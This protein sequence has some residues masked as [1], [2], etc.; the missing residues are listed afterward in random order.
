MTTS[1]LA[2]STPI[3]SQ[4]DVTSRSFASMKAQLIAY[5]KRNFP[6][7]TSFVESDLG[8]SLIEQ[9]CYAYAVIAFYQDQLGNEVY[10]DTIRDPRNMQLALRL[11]GYEMGLPTPASVNVVI[12]PDTI[13]NASEVVIP[14]GT[15][16]FSSG[17]LPFETL[18]EYTIIAL[19]AAPHS[20]WTVNGKQ[21]SVQPVIPVVQ[22][23][24]QSFST[25]GNGEPFQEITLIAT[26]VIDKS[27]SITIGGVPWSEVES[28]VIGDLEDNT[29]LNVFQVVIDSGGNGRLLFGDGVNGAIPANGSAIVGTY[30]TGGGSVGNVAI[31]AINTSVEVTV[32]GAPGSITVYNE[33]TA[34]GGND[35]E[36]IEHARYFGPLTV[37]TT[38]RAITYGDYF[39]L[40]N[41]FHS[42]SAGTVAKAGIVADPTDGISNVVTV[43]IWAADENGDIVAGTSQALKDAL[44]TFLIDRKVVT[45]S[46][47]VVDG[48][49]VPVDLKARIVT[50]PGYDP[51]EV[52][53]AVA[54]RLESLFSDSRV[55]Y[56]NELRGSWVYDI[57]QSTPGVRWCVI[58]SVEGSTNPS[59]FDPLGVMQ[60]KNHTAQHLGEDDI[61][62]TLTPTNQ[63]PPSATW[64]RFN[65]N[66]PWE[67][68][69]SGPIEYL[70]SFLVADVSV[71]GSIGASQPNHTAPPPGTA[72]NPW[73]PILDHFSDSTDTPNLSPGDYANI[74]VVPLDK[75]TSA[76]AAGL[77]AP[78]SSGQGGWTARIA[79]PRL[80]RLQG[81]DL[82]FKDQY[83]FHSI[84]LTDGT[85]KGQ[86]RTIVR[87]WSNGFGYT[88]LF[89]EVVQVDKDWD[90]IPDDTT[91]YVILP[92][93][94]V[95]PDMTMVRGNIEVE[96]LDDPLAS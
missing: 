9:I 20:E 5:W 39:A 37:K 78:V 77:Y 85:G 75:I 74:G 42:S 50:S 56:D 25:T 11:I 2:L 96:I 59:P 79:H 23:E 93:L 84:Y 46:V 28:L 83:R 89:D 44:K 31:Q 54:E 8:V 58:T 35:A 14:A 62:W 92:N 72:G 3:G 16:V 73:L 66:H 29:N 68:G 21:M 86:E 87:S 40:C 70:V 12:D 24:T 32:D 47:E 65:Q 7:Y 13:A 19:D 33:Q 82:V 67:Y 18:K 6:E 49:V 81:G 1:P 34:T 71:A 17:G 38:D 53:A 36:D 43:F 27:L 94:K 88:P 91:E 90:T 45:V 15:Q 10:I 52:K 95:T 64:L 48:V 76:K 60:E 30:R 55:R 26:P 22:G 51:D 61:V 80:M 57:V 63:I 41:G 69:L 4:I